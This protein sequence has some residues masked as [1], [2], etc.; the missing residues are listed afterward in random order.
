[1]IK[2]LNNKDSKIA[3]SIYTVFQASYKIEA[4]ILGVENF[5]PLKRT[6]EDFINSDSL[7]YAFFETDEVAAVIE[8]KIIGNL[9]DIQSLVVHPNFFR[10]GI[11]MKLMNY[12]LKSHSSQ[13]CIVE[14]GLENK[15]AV[16]LYQKLGFQ[17]IETWKTDFGI[18]KVKFEK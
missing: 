18:W 14:T 7:F 9:T 12:V 13:S 17:E 4:D 8:I 1:M 3:K 16:K 10:R 15:P 2:Q 6:I 11:A 5:P